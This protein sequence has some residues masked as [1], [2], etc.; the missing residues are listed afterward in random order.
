[1]I[2]NMAVGIL[3]SGTEELGPEI[4]EAD[5]NDWENGL[6]RKSYF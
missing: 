6:G 4:Y 3:D 1:M 2:W 5:W